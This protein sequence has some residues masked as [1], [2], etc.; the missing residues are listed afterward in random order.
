MDPATWISLVGQAY[1]MFQTIRAN[2]QAAGISDADLE[3]ITADYDARIA[4]REAEAQ[5]PVEG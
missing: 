3:A 4:R 2:A 5:P 1:A